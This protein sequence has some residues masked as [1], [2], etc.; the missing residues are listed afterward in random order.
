MS[1]YR[2]INNTS[3]PVLAGGYVVPAFGQ[4]LVD[5]DIP[6]LGSIG[7]LVLVDGVAQEPNTLATEVTMEKVPNL[8]LEQEPVTE[9]AKR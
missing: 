4:I 1:V 6:E 8:D 2:Y 9:V 7:L 5:Y 3:I